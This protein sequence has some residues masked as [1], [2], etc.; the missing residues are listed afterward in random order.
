M[1]KSYLINPRFFIIIALIILLVEIS[2]FIFVEEKIGLFATLSLV[3]L[4]TMMG[5]VLLRIKGII[6]LR[7]IKRKL[8]QGHPL[9]NYIINDVFIII[10][11]ILLI[12][13]GFVSDILGIL[14]LIKPSHTV[15]WYL[16]LSFYN[17]NN[18][19]MKNNAGIKSEEIIELKAKDYKI[20]DI[21]E[22]PW[23]KNNDT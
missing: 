3:I 14:L 7:N 9:E 10:G 15:V 19:Y 21:K 11:A 12:L 20:Y 23:R 22:S 5:T 13:P 16:F 4:T 18:T 1:I 17:K 8:I 2:S 6:L